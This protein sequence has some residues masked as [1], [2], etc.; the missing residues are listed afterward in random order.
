MESNHNYAF[1]TYFF[2]SLNLYSV[3]KDVI[4]PSYPVNAEEASLSLIVQSKVCPSFRLQDWL[5]Q[6]IFAS[7]DDKKFQELRLLNNNI[8]LCQNINPE[9][10]KTDLESFL[11]LSQTIKSIVKEAEQTGLSPERFLKPLCFNDEAMIL[12]LSGEE[13]DWPRYKELEEEKMQ[14]TTQE[15][16]RQMLVHSNLL[17]FLSGVSVGK[18]AVHEGKNQDNINQNDEVIDIDYIILKLLLLFRVYKKIQ[19][20][21]PDDYKKWRNHVLALEQYNITQ[22]MDELKDKEK[23]LL[24]VFRILEIHQKELLN[25]CFDVLHNPLYSQQYKEDM[26]NILQKKEFTILL[27]YYYQHCQEQNIPLEQRYSLGN[28]PNEYIVHEDLSYIDSERPDKN[29]EQH[30]GLSFKFDT[31]KYLFDNIKGTYIDPDTD[32]RLFCYR[33][34]GK[35]K[36]DKITYL[37]WVADEKSLAFFIKRLGVSKINCWQKTETFFGNNANNLKTIYSRLTDAKG[38]IKTNEANIKMLDPI[39]AK[40]LNGI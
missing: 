30:F 11:K 19:N 8:N 20:D 6:C 35:G 39:I 29:K 3:W 23:L 33:L 13:K 26:I 16:T 27:P 32:I 38:N 24:F 12:L 5:A 25:I 1:V 37:K 31:V 40:A 7:N 4:E 36:P 10:Y 21:Y 15:P 22:F 9:A 18:A 28:T 34:T 14:Q 2:E 17:I